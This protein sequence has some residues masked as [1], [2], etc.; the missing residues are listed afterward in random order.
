MLSAVYTGKLPFRDAALALDAQ[1]LDALAARFRLTPGRITSAVITAR[2]YAHWRAAAQT[3]DQNQALS[4]VQTTLSDLFASARERSS[5]EIETL[6]YEINEDRELRSVAPILQR[7][8]DGTIDKE[9]PPARIKL[10]YCITAWSAA[11]QTPD[12][13][14]NTPEQGPQ[15]EEHMLL[16]PGTGG[17]LEVPDSACRLSGKPC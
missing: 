15:L 13:G 10:S 2:K 12:V 6:L 3:T 8:S 17:P 4:A 7:K 9:L 14:P 11:P 5:H 16:S 1:D